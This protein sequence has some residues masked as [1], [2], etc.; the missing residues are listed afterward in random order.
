MNVDTDE[1]VDFNNKYDE[2]KF[3]LEDDIKE[4]EEL[5]LKDLKQWCEA[6]VED[7]KDQFEE[8]YN[9][10]DEIL[11]DESERERYYQEQEYRNS[12]L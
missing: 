10:N 8:I 1:L 9:R 4:C 12:K 5:G 6:T 7:L 11:T 3:Y 2:I